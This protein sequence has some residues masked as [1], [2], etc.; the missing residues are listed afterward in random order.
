M[1]G[2]KHILKIGYLRDTVDEPLEN[3]QTPTIL[4]QYKERL[5]GGHQLCFTK[6]IIVSR[7]QEDVSPMRATAR[8]L[9]ERLLFLTWSGKRKGPCQLV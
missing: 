6:V 8:H 5:M 1:A 9:V 3:T 4:C 2:I 7:L